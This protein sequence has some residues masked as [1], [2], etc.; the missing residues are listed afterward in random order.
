MDFYRILWH[1]ICRLGRPFTYTIREW[2]RQHP[3]LVRLLAY[4][5]C[6]LMVAGQILLPW[7]FGF[8]AVPFVLAADGV[9]IIIGHLYWDTLG[10][11]IKHEQDLTEP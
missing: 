9:F 3:V 8:W 10:P 1:D 6:L 7:R 2:S 4:T 11:F 5:A